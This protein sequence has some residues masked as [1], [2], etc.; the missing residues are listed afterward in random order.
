MDPEI[1]IPNGMS[2]YIL[3]FLLADI[4]FLV[5]PKFTK[6]LGNAPCLRH[7]IPAMLLSFPVFI[8]CGMRDLFGLYIMICI[9]L[10]QA[11]FA[12]ATHLYPPVPDVTRGEFARTYVGIA[13]F[14]TFWTALCVE[15]LAWSDMPTS[16]SWERAAT[17]TVILACWVKDIADLADA[18]RHSFGTVRETDTTWARALIGTA[19]LLPDTATVSRRLFYCDLVSVA[20]CVF[21]FPTPAL[22]AVTLV[23][24]VLALEF[25]DFDRYRRHVFIKTD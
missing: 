2:L 15:L 6:S 25:D 23:W 14:R 21:I 8:M 4:F 12:L 17:K 13:A 19:S 16:M 11:V 22:C 10:A 9:W 18:A 1:V 20:C 24:L 5:V 3:F 7:F